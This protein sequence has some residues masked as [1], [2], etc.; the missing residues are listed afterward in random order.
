ME[1]LNSDLNQLR[2]SIRVARYDVDPVAVADAIVRRRWSL[3][4]ATRGAGR[5]PP[6]AGRRGRASVSCIARRG[7]GRA[8]ERLAA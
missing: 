3:T 2:D 8:V 6:A 7:P 1:H 4:V 5:V